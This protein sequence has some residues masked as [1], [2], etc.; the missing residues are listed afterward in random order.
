MRV[1]LSARNAGTDQIRLYYIPQFGSEFTVAGRAKVTVKSGAAGAIESSQ[2]I[3]EAGMLGSAAFENAYRGKS[4]TIEG[5]FLRVEQHSA[6][7]LGAAA[8]LLPGSNAGKAYAALFLG[9]TDAA[10][11]VDG[12][13]SEL[14]CLVPADDPTL[15]A[16]AASLKSGEAVVVRGTPMGWGPVSGSTAV[17]VGNCQLVP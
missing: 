8:K 9:W 13:P 15:Q 16:R 11:K 5:Q 14:V 2:L 4:L 17:M 12:A 7:D 10:P 1:Y 3:R 6:D